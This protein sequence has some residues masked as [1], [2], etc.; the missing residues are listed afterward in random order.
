[1]KLQSQISRIYKEKEY[2]KNWIVIP[3]TILKDL[4]WKDGEE[5]ESKVNGKELIIKKKEK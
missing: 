3:T 1:M 5:L 4:K 2:K